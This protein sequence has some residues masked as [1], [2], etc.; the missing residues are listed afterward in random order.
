[1][2]KHQE[3]EAE[4]LR[5]SPGIGLPSIPESEL[6]NA[7][8]PGTSD[9]T[10]EEIWNRVEALN[11]LRINPTM[12]DLPNWYWGFL[13]GWVAISLSAL[14][15]PGSPM[16]PAIFTSGFAGFIILTL[17]WGLGWEQETKRRREQHLAGIP[18][19]HRLL[20]GI[21]AWLRDLRD[22]PVTSGV[23]CPLAPQ[24]TR[25]GLP[26]RTV[27]LIRPGDL[28]PV[29]AGSSLRDISNDVRRFCW[30]VPHRIGDE[31]TEARIDT[32]RADLLWAQ[33]AEGAVCLPVLARVVENRQFVQDWH[34]IRMVTEIWI[35]GHADDLLE[36]GQLLDRTRRVFPSLMSSLYHVPVMI[37]GERPSAALVSLI[38]SRFAN[39]SY[40]EPDGEMDTH[41]TNLS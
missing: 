26:L 23:A 21:G 38:Q 12:R 34:P 4:E 33:G 18:P 25:I 36:V 22:D 1:M 15:F 14:L 8:T 2:L 10:F 40:A 37:L 30:E 3:V 17:V 27:L 5:L 29:L 39:V 19:L 32:I 6:V 28:Q 24:L 41:E 31:L 7:A 20:M 11:S 9:W 35:D 13:G 16:A